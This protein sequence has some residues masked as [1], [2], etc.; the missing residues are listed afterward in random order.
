MIADFHGTEG[1]ARLLAYWLDELD[2][3]EALAIEEHLFECAEC[4]ERLRGTLQLGA[5]VRRA[6]LDGDVGTAVTPAFLARMRNGGVRL[7]EYRLPP[8][9]SVLC[10][11]AP[12]DDFVVSRLEAQLAGVRRVDLEFEDDGGTRRIAHIP[13]D[14]ASNEV[15]F[16]PPAATLRALGRTTQRMRLFAVTGDAERLLGEYT[17]NHTPWG[18]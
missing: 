16:M 15:A 6:L 10:T 14:A 5:A 7:R 9:G 4:A 1:E 11:I 12:D 2:E 13:F 8:G 18:G 3:A 17:F